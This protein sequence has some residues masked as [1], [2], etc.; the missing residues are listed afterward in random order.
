MGNSALAKIPIFK[1]NCSGVK[2]KAS[3]QEINLG[4]NIVIS[5][6]K[7]TS[8]GPTEAPRSPPAAIKAYINT[9]LEEKYFADLRLHPNDKGFEY[10]AKNILEQIKD[11]K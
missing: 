8:C 4:L 2:L 7:P 1:P 9:P 11:K 10:Y 3:A 5:V 6:S